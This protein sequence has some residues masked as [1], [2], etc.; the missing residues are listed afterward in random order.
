MRN[1][2]STKD[3]PDRGQARKDSEKELP[4]QCDKPGPVKQKCNLCSSNTFHLL[5]QSVC[6]L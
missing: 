3:A 1:K 2:G 5:F 4:G 6:I